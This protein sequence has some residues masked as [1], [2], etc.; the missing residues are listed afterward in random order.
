MQWPALRHNPINILHTK[1]STWVR[2]DGYLPHTPTVATPVD[3]TPCGEER[4]GAWVGGKELGWDVILQ[5]WWWGKVVNYVLPQQQ[6]IEPEYSH[7]L[8]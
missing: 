5:K 2:G 8:Y 7:C 1:H 6:K 3:S 4:R